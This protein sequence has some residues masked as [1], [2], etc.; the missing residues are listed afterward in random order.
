MFDLDAPSFAVVAIELDTELKLV[1]EPVRGHEPEP[2]PE[3][4]HARA[5]VLGLERERAHVL[6]LELVLVL[7]RIAVVARSPSPSDAIQDSIIVV[8]EA[9]TIRRD[10]N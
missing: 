4:E 8:A 9:L 1:L 10:I 2:E 5:P 7:E 3:P 6:V